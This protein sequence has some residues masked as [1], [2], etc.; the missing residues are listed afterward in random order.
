MI[1]FE[2]TYDAYVPD[3]QMAG[4]VARPV[5]LR[6]PGWRWDP[7]ELRRRSRPR[8]RAVIL[9]TP[10]NPT[11]KVFSRRRARGAGAAVHR[12]RRRR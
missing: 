4:G 10:H 12:A 6:L 9:N 5:A 3:I 8:T 2:P 11:G 7:A 1:V